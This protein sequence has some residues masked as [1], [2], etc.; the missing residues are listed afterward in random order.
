MADRVVG[1]AGS[2]RPR[3]PLLPGF[4]PDPSIVRVGGFF[5]LVTSSF[6]YLPGLPVYRSADL[7]EWVHIGNVLTRP[8]QAD[9]RT[10]PTPGG[11]WAPTIRHRDGQFYVIVSLMFGGQGCLVFTAHNPEG[12]WSD[13]TPIPAVDGYDPDLVWDDDGTALVTYARLGRGVFQVAVNLGDGTPLDEPRELWSGTGLYAAEGPHIYRRGGWWYLLVAEGGTERGHAISVARSRSASGPFIGHESNPVLTHRSTGHP[14]QNVGHADMVDLSDG[15]SLWVVLGVRPVG[16]TRAFSPLGRET[17]AAKVEWEDGWPQPFFLP[18]DPVDDAAL[19]VIDFAADGATLD[20]GWMSDRRLPSTVGRIDQKWGAF[21]L[22]GEGTDLSV[23]GT[24]MLVRRVT[25][26]SCAIALRIDATRGVGG[27]VIRNSE[28]HWIAIE[29]DCTADTTVVTARAA[30]AGFE[31]SWSA[32][33]PGKDLVLHAQFLVPQRHAI[34]VG[35][36]AVGG[37]RIT[38]SVSTEIDNIALVELDGRYWCFETTESFTGRV[39]GAYAREG[40]VA[41]ISYTARNMRL[42]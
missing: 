22:T 8:E 17:F 10:T 23:P 24:P 5:Y 34:G 16:F 30:L 13:G 2:I 12:P 38:L 21:V 33:V 25:S 39:V 42:G 29:V 6:E 15:T 9:L 18:L 20:A 32:T 7:R 40:E 4:N 36:P 26:H 11:V 37:D 31:R 19:E 41:L 3:Q 27:L 1:S 14:V 35:A 28:V